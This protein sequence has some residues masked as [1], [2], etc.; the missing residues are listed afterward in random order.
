M[1]EYI[2]EQF[3]HKGF[4]IKLIQDPDADDPLGC[5]ADSS[6]FIV[7]TRNRHFEELH[8]GRD[9]KQCM[10]D[11]ELRAKYWVFPVNAYIHSGVALSLGTEYPFNCPWDSGHIGFISRPKANGATAHAKQRSA[12]QRS[13]PQPAISKHGTNT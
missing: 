7:T 11:K 12:V 2:G 1:R 4:N 3:M 5:G 10:E 9:A 8:E 13:K 6:L